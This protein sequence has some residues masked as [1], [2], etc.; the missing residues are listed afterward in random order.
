MAL[1]SYVMKSSQGELIAWPIRLLGTGASAPTVEK[2]VGIT[3]TRTDTGDYT[4]TWSELPGT[5]ITALATLRAATPNDLAGHTIVLDTFASN[6]LPMTL[7][8]ASDAAHDLAANEY[9]DIVAF[10]ARAPE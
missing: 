4:V 6:A 10:F 1:D 5:F 8:N 7:A 2:G 9:I 3:C